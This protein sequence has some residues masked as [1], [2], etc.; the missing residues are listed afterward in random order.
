MEPLSHSSRR[1][2]VKW[3][4]LAGLSWLTPLSHVLAHAAEQKREPAR[5]V[6]LLWMA[7]GPS[8]LETFDPHPGTDIAAGTGAIKTAAKGVQLAS[9]FE[10]LAEQMESV[11]LVRSLVSKEGDHE[12]GTYTLKTGHRPDPTVV[13]PSLG[14]ILCHDLPDASTDIPRHVSILPGQ[15]PA[16]GG[17]LG[18]EYDAFKVHDPAQ[19]VPDVTPHAPPDRFAQRLKD[20][21]IVEDVF[22]RG[23]RPRVEATQHQ[24][25][26]ERARKMMTSEQ[27]RAFDVT[28]EPAA[29]RRDYGDTPFGRGCLAARRLIEAGVRCVEVTLDGWDTH[30]NNHELVGKR[31]AELDPAFAALV[32]DLKQHELL[33]RTIVICVGE[34]GRTPKMNPLG[35]RD[36]WP[37]NFC[38]AVAGGGLRGGVV[39]GASDPE[40]GTKPKDPQPV[41]NLHATVLTA[42]GIDPKKNLQSPIRRTFPRADGEPIQALLA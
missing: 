34:F 26:M 11:S 8:Q 20:L 38:A 13:H 16:R 37:H 22:A 17:F 14:A 5:S 39:V 36:H 42:L 2:F 30:A 9:G 15:W 10:R 33:Q 12:R 28:R 29:L 19:P 32:R 24:P 7:G 35:G 25:T 27:L 18:D 23:R 40:G 4:A 6:I 31:V 41:G 3:S 1:D 21:Q